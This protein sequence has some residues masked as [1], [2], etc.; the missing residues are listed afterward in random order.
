[1]VRVGAGRLRIVPKIVRHCAASSPTGRP[2]L[3]SEPPRCRAMLTSIHTLSCV[4]QRLRSR[5]DNQYQQ[6]ATV[7]LAVCRNCH[8]ALRDQRDLF[9]RAM[10]GWPGQTRGRDFS[11]S[12]LFRSFRADANRSSFRGYHAQR[13]QTRLRS[14][15]RFI[16]RKTRTPARRDCVR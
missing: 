3:V 11:Y 9:L 13:G 8:R 10:A 14:G 1:M 2:Q 4:V 7:A 16:G 12:R 15:A 6:T 5:R